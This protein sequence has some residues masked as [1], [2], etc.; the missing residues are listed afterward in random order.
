MRKIFSFFTVIT[1]I[2]SIGLFSGLAEAKKF[3]G[4][5]SFGRSYK[6]APSQPNQPV[7]TMNPTVNKA[8]QPNK[9][10]LMGGLLG[11]LLAGGLFAWLLGSGAF[12][13]IQMFDMLIMAAVAFML[14][15]FLQRKKSQTQQQPATPFGS[16][17]F[18]HQFRTD[19]TSSGYQST[20]SYTKPESDIPFNIPMGF[21][22]K[23]FL[24]GSLEHYRT[25]QEAWNTNDFS[26]IQEYVSP[27]LFNELKT[28]RNNYTDRLHTE[29]MFINAE[30]VRAQNSG[31]EAQLSVLFK[32]RYK[33]TIEQIEEDIHEV[34]HLERNLTQDNSPWIIVG[35][36]NK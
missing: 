21:D 18:G 31:K 15:K 4:S 12:D 3:G 1:L 29:I 30:L 10:G 34:W 16:T 19:E 28:E 24:Q 5:K 2:L 20:E 9:S 25:L 7:N 17:N 23:M 35:I 26:K 14:F 27:E 22:T 11:G 13:G 32:G 36:E 8:S 6:T 33:D